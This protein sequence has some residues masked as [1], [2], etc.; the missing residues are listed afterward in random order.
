M[1]LPASAGASRDTA[2]P[3]R[4][5]RSRSAGVASY[6]IA[7]DNNDHVHDQGGFRGWWRRQ[8]HRAK[9]IGR[10]IKARFS[11]GANPPTP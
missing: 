2:P 8:K 4:N 6:Q 5:E 1:V 11:S 9:V 7:H 10:K 3:E